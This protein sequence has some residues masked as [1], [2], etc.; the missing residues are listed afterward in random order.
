MTRNPAMRWSLVFALMAFVSGSLALVALAQDDGTDEPTATEAVITSEAP[1]TPVDLTVY[2]TGEVQVAIEPTGDNGY[3]TICHNQPGETLRLEDGTLL[4]LYVAPELVAS[5]VHG[6]SADSPGLGCLDCHGEDSFPHSGPPPADGRVNTINSNSM[7][8][9]CHEVHADELNMGLHAQA[10]ANGNTAAAV[11]TD[12]HSAHHVQTAEFRPEIMAGVCAD[13]HATVHDQWVIS[14]HADIGPLGCATCHDYHAQTLRVGETT[15][16][17]CL[18]CH[19]DNL[20]DL[21]VHETHITAVQGSDNPVECADCH[22]VEGDSVDTAL[23]ISTEEGLANHSML[24]DA[25]PCNTCHT[26][27]AASGEWDEILSARVSLAAPEDAEADETVDI[28]LEGAS[29][30]GTAIIGNTPGDFRF[31]IQGLLL[32]LGLGVTFAIVFF[33]RGR[34]DAPANDRPNNEENTDA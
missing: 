26:D 20:P 10:I 5:S 32:G 2:D 29:E 3:C 33:T 13:C 25:T 30:A 22:M 28:T 34:S 12:C 4:N 14:D 9:S 7:C 27:L 6:P 18:N 17:L 21:F 16:D 8:T 24:L 15:T 11:C 1:M 19:M 31:A 23:T